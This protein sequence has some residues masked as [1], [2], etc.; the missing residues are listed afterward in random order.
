[1]ER[2]PRETRES[3]P[4]LDDTLGSQEDTIVLKYLMEHL[5]RFLLVDPG[6]KSVA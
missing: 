3:L 4:S 1:M 2:A 5:Q 6:L